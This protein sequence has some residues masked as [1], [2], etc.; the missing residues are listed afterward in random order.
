[1]PVAQPGLFASHTSQR[2]SA[3]G[4]D[5]DRS[6]VYGTLPAMAHSASGSTWVTRGAVQIMPKIAH[7]GDGAA[8]VQ[9]GRDR[10]VLR[11]ALVRHTRHDHERRL[12][13]DEGDQRMTLRRSSSQSRRRTTRSAVVRDPFR[14]TTS[15]RKHVNSLC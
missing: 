4:P 11:H 8:V 5:Q 3:P 12:S 13:A 15:Y 6:T 2:S 1:M 10:R 9:Q 7:R 14:S